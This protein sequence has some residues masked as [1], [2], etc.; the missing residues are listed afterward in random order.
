M[1]SP[2]GILR[3]RRYWAWAFGAVGGLCLAGVL[4]A[5]CAGWIGAGA[6]V[7]ASVE[8]WDPTLPLA[9]LVI[10]YVLHFQP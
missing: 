8:F 2:P 9:P 3:R 7:S 4:I 6:T 5:G 1:N 10:V